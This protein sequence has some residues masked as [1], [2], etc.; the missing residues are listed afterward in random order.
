MGN[1]NNRG[2][3]NEIHIHWIV[4]PH[5]SLSFSFALSLPL[6]LSPPSPFLSFSLSPCPPLPL[7]Q[8]D[9]TRIMTPVIPSSQRQR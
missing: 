9:E 7:T 8:K 5:L 4:S 3:L 2:R 1:D 6:S